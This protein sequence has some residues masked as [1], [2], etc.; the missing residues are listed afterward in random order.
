M[1]AKHEYAVAVDGERL[2]AYVA[3][4]VPGISR[5][6]ARRLIEEKYVTLDGSPARPSTRVRVGQR[7]I[8]ELPDAS[9]P[10]DLPQRIA[11]GVVHEDESIIVVDKPAGLVVHPTPAQCDGTLLNALLDRCP[12][13]PDD[14]SMRRGI[15]HRIDKDTSGLL[16]VAKTESAYADL[17]TQLRQRAFHKMYLALVRGRIEPCRATIESPIARDP[18]NRQRMA[19]VEGGREA[20]SQ[21]RVLERHPGCSLVEVKLVTGRTHQ[22]RVQVASLGHPVVGDRTYG[23]G[24]HSIARQFL[25]AAVLGFRHP[26][27][28]EHVVFSS[29]LPPD[30]RGFLE[31]VARG[32]DRLTV[33]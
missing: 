26:E 33:R 28:G 12:G 17:T 32:R 2:D 23:R 29:E 10:G 30:L 19:V 22:I 14:P 9:M 13:L 7:V 25:H 20:I 15:V 31:R 6:R 24:P 3:S 4:K 11:F 8:A 21:Y 18:A 16:V 5:S 1:S 27:S